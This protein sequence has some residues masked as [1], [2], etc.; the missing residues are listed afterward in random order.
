[1]R[2][3][4]QQWPTPSYLSFMFRRERMKHWIKLI[5]INCEECMLFWRVSFSTKIWVLQLGIAAWATAFFICWTS[6]LNILYTFWFCR[7]VPDMKRPWLALCYTAKATITYIIWT[8]SKRNPKQISLG[9]IWTICFLYYTKCSWLYMQH[10]SH[11]GGVYNCA[12][13][14]SGGI[15]EQ[16][17]M[18]S[19]VAVEL[20]CCKMNRE[21]A[22]EYTALY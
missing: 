4:E 7:T 8:V 2:G 21:Y 3:S 16:F 19:A 14:C 20:Y 18:F 1:M 9:R 12:L 11:P 15:S 5:H 22:Y 13:C 10:S 17:Y 6:I